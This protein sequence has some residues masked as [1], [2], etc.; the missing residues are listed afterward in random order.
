MTLRQ[1]TEAWMQNRLVQWQSAEGKLCG[2]MPV[3]MELSRGEV[4]VI[5]KTWDAL[6]HKSMRFRLVDTMRF[7]KIR[8]EFET[9]LEPLT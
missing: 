1:L 5:F 3:T 7:D 8:Q 2:G 6:G 4:G 9:D